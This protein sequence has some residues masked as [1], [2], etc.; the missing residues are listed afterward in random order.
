MEWVSPSYKAVCQGSSGNGL[1]Y[2]RDSCSFIAKH[3]LLNSWL[4]SRKDYGIW[5]NML[6]YMVAHSLR[7]R[8]IQ[9][10]DAKENVAINSE[11]LACWPSMVVSAEVF[12]RSCFHPGPDAW[13]RAHQEFRLIVRWSTA[14]LGLQEG[15]NLEDVW[16]C[17]VFPVLLSV[18]VKVVASLIVFAFLVW[19][20]L[21]YFWNSYIFNTPANLNNVTVAGLG[22][23]WIFSDGWKPETLIFWW[24]TLKLAIQVW[25]FLMKFSLKE[26]ECGKCWSFEW[27]KGEILLLELWERGYLRRVAIW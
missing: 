17:I 19:V 11:E 10:Q 18:S 16:F 8:L 12:C 6:I 24:V 13:R 15:Q 3:S 4:D 20:D 27:L 23:S 5:Y 2:H 25:Q 14:T 22:H 7:S 9:W 1:L 26:Y 21:L